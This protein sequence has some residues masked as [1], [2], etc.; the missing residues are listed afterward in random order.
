MKNIT[1]LFLLIST[2]GICQKNRIP[3]KMIGEFDKILNDPTVLTKY[4]FT[5]N[6]PFKHIL[7][8]VDFGSNYLK[9]SITI[10]NLENVH[11]KYITYVYSEYK[12]V[13][14]FKQ[15]ELNRERLYNLKKLMPELFNK[16]E[17]EWNTVMQTGATSTDEAENLFHGFIVNYRPLPSPESITRE[18]EYMK[19]MVDSV[20]T[21]ISPVSDTKTLITTFN[22]EN[23]VTIIAGDHYVSEMGIALSDSVFTSPTGTFN[24]G[25]YFKDSTVSTVLN[26]NK[27][28]NKMLINCDLTGSMSPYS[29]QLLVWHKLN[30]DKSRVQHF[31]FFNDGDYTPDNRKIAG[32]TGGVYHSVPN[33]FEQLQK[34][35]YKCMKNGG[36]GDAPENDIEAILKGL[37]KCEN[38]NDIILIADNWAN[39]RDY[40][41]IEEIGKPVRIILCGTHFG[42][43]KQYLNLARKTKGSIHTIEEDISN[44][45][46]LRE[47]EKVTISGHTFLIKKGQFVKK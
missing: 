46:D 8:P 33:D 2:L 35:A 25:S 5:S 31:V 37:K 28:W 6:S 13:K 29:A 38:C 1:I 24:Y 45:M 32:S 21:F 11:I 44:L 3:N 26:R 30:M 39:M 20:L 7:I 40:K 43:N 23:S 19:S 47:G 9:D 36:G 27:H 18:I 17:I 34:K 4:D 15:F 42:I 41:F 10:S 22:T 12:S 16:E 14:D